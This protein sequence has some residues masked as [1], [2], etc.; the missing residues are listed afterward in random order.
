MP[1]RYSTP[2]GAVS[3]KRRRGRPRN[4]SQPELASA[5]RTIA[6]TVHRLAM[7]GFPLRGKDGVL[8]V[9][10]RLARDVLHRLGESGDPAKH[11]Q[12]LSEIRVEQILEA[13]RNEERAGRHWT[14]GNDKG[15][16]PERWRYPVN[17]LRVARPR[18]GW[19]LQRYARKLLAN[20]GIWRGRRGPTPKNWPIRPVV[21]TPK[22][23]KELLSMPRIRR[24]KTG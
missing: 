15:A 24:R 10:A 7:W 8:D 16:L 23:E 12:P 14:T 18:Q 20:G 21:L 9:V 5:D 22:A 3:S 17:Y 6:L 13:W 1:E 4:A 19:G 2:R 11:P